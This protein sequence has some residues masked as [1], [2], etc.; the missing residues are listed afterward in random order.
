MPKKKILFLS[1]PIGSGHIRAAQAICNAL[2]AQ[3]HDVEVK[4]V[5]VFDFFNSILGNTI[6]KIYLKI[7]KA[8]PQLYAKAYSWGNGSRLALM[9]RRMVSGCLA[10]RMYPYILDYKPELIVCTHATPAGLIAYL[11]NKRRL[12][13]PFLAVITD[14][15]VHRLWVYQEVS[16]YFVANREMQIYL[17]R[18]GVE[19]SK[20]DIYGIPVDQN[21][22]MRIDKEKILKKLKLC[23]NIKT[24]LVMGGG[25][26][27]LPMEEIVKLCDQ[28]DMNVQIITVT[29]KNKAM[30][31][32]LRKIQTSL[33]AS[34]LIFGYVENVHELMAVADVLISK[35]GGMTSAE[36]LC[37]GLPMIIYQP[38]PG[39][40]EANT[41]YL[42]AR[43]VALRADST[44]QL[45]IILNELLKDTQY[46]SILR[47]N[48][49]A[50]AQPD[51]A[52]HIADFIIKKIIK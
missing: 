47:R 3:N 26:G 13:I 28:L 46:L 11:A 25:A 24:I 10:K 40:E 30:Y 9:G 36:A 44:G 43:E 41:A 37:M 21:F 32:T 42:L 52:K 51:A 27:V 38:I 48:A 31:L 4:I 1:A 8:F 16:H 7:L 17:G 23:G 49:A 14:Y 22:T 20:S 50:L 33:R 45:K 12:Q 18:Y 2:C 39:Q 19:P 15:V 34:L 5:N 29:G 6:I 35:P